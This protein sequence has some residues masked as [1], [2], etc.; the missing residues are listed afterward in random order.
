MYQTKMWTNKQQQPMMLVIAGRKRQSSNDYD[1]N[2]APPL[3]KSCNGSWLTENWNLWT[4]SPS[5]RR[6]E[7]WQHRARLLL[8][9]P[10]KLLVVT[11]RAARCFDVGWWGPQIASEISIMAR[12][13][14]LCTRKFWFLCPC[15]VWVGFF[16]KG[17]FFVWFRWLEN[18]PKKFG[19]WLAR[20]IL[21]EYFLEQS[22]FSG[23]SSIRYLLTSKVY[24][25]RSFVIVYDVIMRKK[26]CVSKIFFW[27]SYLLDARTL[28]F[29][30]IV[31]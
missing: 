4:V 20:K 7:R 9:A 2:V 27:I 26:N 5:L 1:R 17:A 8:S 25:I 13:L 24:A 21:C 18:A 6:L 30:Y 29:T 3:C 10:Q 22:Q 19:V 16:G 11:P 12:L 23:E 14:L 28:F 31:L 15:W